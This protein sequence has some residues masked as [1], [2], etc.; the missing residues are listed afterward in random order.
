M[1]IIGLFPLTGN[2]GI[3]SWTRKFLDTFPDETYQFETIDI[4]PASDREG[5]PDIKFIRITTGIKAFF[6]IR[7][8]LKLLL[9]TRKF[10]ILHTTTSGKLGTMRDLMVA[11]LCKRYNVKSIM[12]CRY[13]CITEDITGCGPFAILLRRTMRLYDQIWVLD[14]RSFE[15][16]KKIGALADK[17]FLTPNSIDVTEQLDSRPKQ[18]RKI[19]F[20]GNLLP[21]K[22]LYELI[23]AVIKSDA[24]LNIIGP[25][26]SEVIAEIGRLAGNELNLKIKL[27]GKLSNT[28]AVQKLKEADII[29]LPTYYDSEAFPISIIEAMSLT[30]MVISCPRAAIPDM[31]TSLDGTLCGILVEPKSA[32][33]IADAITWCQKNK[34]K[35]DLMCVAAYQ[36]VYSAYRKEIVYDIYRE[37]Y[38][39]LYI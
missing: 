16:L 23:Q 10:D 25:G 9:T 38:N 32:D 4:S 15:S 3:A 36:K 11:R 19:A 29:A 26:T 6:R 18:Y 39:R 30:K 7:K 17:V 20:C 14:S 37:N 13:G 35:A 27:S 8:G 1:N 31:L 2:G 12:H 28:Q 5:K 21:T 34:E 22:G 24:E 33:A